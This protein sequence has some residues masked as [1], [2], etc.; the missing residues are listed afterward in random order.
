[1][2]DNKIIITAALTGVLATR[3]QNP[4]IP[5]TPEEIAEEGG[6]I[7]R[8]NGGEDF[9]LIPCLNEDARW[10]QFLAKR[11]EMWQAGDF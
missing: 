3:Q 1:M 4:N 2:H 6:E 9:G 7:F 5:Y 11:V 10:I 8:E